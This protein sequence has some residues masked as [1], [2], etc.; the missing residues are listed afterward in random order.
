VFC[1]PLEPPNCHIMQNPNT[2]DKSSSMI[3]SCYIFCQTS[4]NFPNQWSEAK[5]PQ[6]MLQRP[7]YGPT[8]SLYRKV[9]IQPH[10]RHPHPHAVLACSGKKQLTN[11]KC[12]TT[13]ECNKHTNFHFVC[14]Y[15][16]IYFFF[17]VNR[18]S[19][20]AMQMQKCNTRACKVQARRALSQKSEI[21]SIHHAP[22]AQPLTGEA[23]LTVTFAIVFR[24][25]ATFL[26]VA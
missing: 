22:A 23:M 25:N 15:I 18:E 10:P 21:P 6:Q 4:G 2:I 13:P 7:L 24:W 26:V 17:L 19:I 16:Y 3:C 11:S 9:W 14:A 1:T 12:D 8:K 5:P 20:G